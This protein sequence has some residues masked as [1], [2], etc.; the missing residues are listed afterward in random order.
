[1]SYVIYAHAAKNGVS[2]SF[3]RDE[4]SSGGTC[5]NAG[6]LPYRASICTCSID[7]IGI[8][9][10]VVIAAGV[11]LGPTVE[12]GPIIVAFPEAPEAPEAEFATGPAVVPIAGGGIAIL[13]MVLV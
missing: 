3:D 8:T 5:C 2:P 1:M 12:V 9:A 6:M 10:A 13:A 7:S 11:I 4:S